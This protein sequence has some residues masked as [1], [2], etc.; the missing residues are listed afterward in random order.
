MPNP[1]VEGQRAANRRSYYKHRATRLQYG[2]DHREQT[3][4]NARRRNRAIKLEAIQHYGNACACCKET[5]IEFLA[6]DHE[7]GNG[8]QHRKDIKCDGG[9]N[10]YKWLKRDLWPEGFR[11]LC[12]NCNMAIGIWG[13]CPHQKDEDNGKD[14]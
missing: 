2:Y 8:N 10:F 11:V 4:A 1:T 9:V 5:I 6:I 12:H 13:S 3:N 7:A 14:E